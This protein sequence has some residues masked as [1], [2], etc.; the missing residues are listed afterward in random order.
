M[1]S[2]VLYTNE[3]YVS[4]PQTVSLSY[5]IRETQGNCNTIPGFPFSIGERQ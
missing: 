1:T 5:V 2:A 3:R 4:L